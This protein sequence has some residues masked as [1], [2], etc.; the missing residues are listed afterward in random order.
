MTYEKQ[1]RYHEWILRKLR[2]ERLEL[3]TDRQADLVTSTDLI[4]HLMLLGFYILFMFT[5]SQPCYL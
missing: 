1:E 4:L 2:E 3:D 5:S